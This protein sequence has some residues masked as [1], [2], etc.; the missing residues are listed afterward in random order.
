MSAF[1]KKFATLDSIASTV[2][3]LKKQGKKIVTTNG[4]FDILHLG[5][6]RYLQEAK[7]LGDILIVGV[8]SDVSVRKL[9]GLERPINKETDR[10]EV[11]AALE[12][13][14][15]V[16]IFP[17]DTPEK[18]LGVI[19]PHVHVKGGDYTGKE[20]PEKKVVEACGGKVHCVS[21]VPGFSTTEILKK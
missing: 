15:Y 9:K 8:N 20:L 18:L 19:Q 4:C 13:I 3:Q 5:H 14:D 6:I 11:L 12:A 7:S 21:H 2:S 16:I 10:A 1:K 17:E